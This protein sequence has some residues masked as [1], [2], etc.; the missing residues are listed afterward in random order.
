MFRGMLSNEVYDEIM[1]LKLDKSCI[2]VPQK[3]IKLSG[4][5]IS[6]ALT[7]IFN[8][9]LLQGIVQDILK[10]SKVTPVAKEEMYA[11]YPT[12]YRP[13]STLS[14]FTADSNIEKACLQSFTLKNTSFFL[15]FNLDL[16]KATQPH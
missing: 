14:A 12:N 6:E 10:I 4:N 7:I 13:I 3:C 15:S 9:S 2:G 16:E 11:M 1:N 8:Q 5:Y